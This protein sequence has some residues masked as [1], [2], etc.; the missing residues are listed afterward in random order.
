GV[1]AASRFEAG[2]NAGALVLGALRESA[3]GTIMALKAGNMMMQC[4]PLAHVE[5]SDSGAPPNN[6]AGGLMPKNARWRECAILDF[7]DVGGADA[8]D[9]HLDE[10]FMGADARDT[11]VFYAQIVRAAIDDGADGFGGG[12][13]RRVLTTYCTD[14]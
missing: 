9:G 13:H 10:Q 14:D 11:N 12:K 3:M 4:H 2:G 6:H 8:A 5:T 1:A 7:F